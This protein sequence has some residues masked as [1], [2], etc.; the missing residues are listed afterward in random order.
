MEAAALERLRRVPLFSELDDDGLVQVG[1]V[2]TDAEVSEG[3]VLIER[4][5]AGAG[6]FILVEGTVEVELP[7]GD[8][9]Q[10]GPGEFFGELAL[11]APGVRTA[12]VRATTHARFMAISRADFTRLLETQP[13]IAVGMVAML[14]RRLATRDALHESDP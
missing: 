12:R 2:T 13:K 5:H 3:H 11:L 10:M 9:R 6:L 7:D 8:A 14:A 1:A 4:G